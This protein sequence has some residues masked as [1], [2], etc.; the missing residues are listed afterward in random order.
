MA[1]AGGLAPRALV[2][3][4]V[5]GVVAG[6]VDSALGALLQRK[7]TCAT[8]GRVVEAAT[9]CGAPPRRL[10]GRLAALDNDGVNLVNGVVGALVAWG[11]VAGGAP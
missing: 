3:A 5:G 1:L 8:C 9:C 4:T 6:Y 7:G 2:P 10:A 11:L